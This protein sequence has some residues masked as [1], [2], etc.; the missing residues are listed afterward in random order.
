MFEDYTEVL[1][2]R[3]VKKEA[4]GVYVCECDQ[5][6]GNLKSLKRLPS[7]LTYSRCNTGTEPVCYW[8]GLMLEGGVC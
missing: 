7:D 4:N 1:R 2:G 3:G 6:V 5:T 8:P